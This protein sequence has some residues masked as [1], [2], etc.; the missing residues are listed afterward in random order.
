MLPARTVYGKTMRRGTCHTLEARSKMS[1]AKLGRLGSS[2]DTSAALAALT[3]KYRDPMFRAERREQ[4]LRAAA[5][6]TFKTRG[7][8]PPEYGREMSRRTTGIKKT[9]TLEQH[10]YLSERSRALALRM[11]R[12][13]KRVEYIDRHGR[14]HQMHSGWERR[15]AEVLDA[16]KCLWAY[17]PISLHLSDGRVYTPDFWVSEIG[18]VEIKGWRGWDRGST[19]QARRDGVPVV[20]LTHPAQFEKAL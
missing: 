7:P 4:N 5:L 8:R 12:T 9:L 19:E 10:Q 3:E 17:E 13:R 11:N 16:R 20:M 14:A 15:F 1:A 18:F 6:S 2:R